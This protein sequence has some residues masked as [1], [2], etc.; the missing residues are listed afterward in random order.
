MLRLTCLAF[1]VTSASGAPAAGQ[2]RGPGLP[3]SCSGGEQ[4]G[5]VLVG[6]LGVDF[7]FRREGLRIDLLEAD[8]F[9]VVVASSTGVSS[10]PSKPSARATGGRPGVA[11]RGA[12][13]MAVAVAA[14]CSR[15]S[16]C[17]LRTRVTATALPRRYRPGGSPGHGHGVADHGGLGHAGSNRYRHKDPFG[18]IGLQVVAGTPGRRGDWTPMDPGQTQ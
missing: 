5:P 7:E 11:P 18:F 10:L 8:E 6:G 12:G 14:T 4:L 9:Q 13:D 3:P 1:G 16:S 17:S 15:P 2:V